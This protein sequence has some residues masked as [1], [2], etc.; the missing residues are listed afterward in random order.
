MVEWGGIYFLVFFVFLDL[1]VENFFDVGWGER[2]GFGDFAVLVDPFVHQKVGG[3]AG[4]DFGLIWGGYIGC[5][6]RRRL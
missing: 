3:R 4:V 5:W 1:F 2:R 6:L